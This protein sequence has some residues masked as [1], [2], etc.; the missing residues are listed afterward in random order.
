MEEQIEE[1]WMYEELVWCYTL[2]Y[3]KELTVA[4]L[5][6]LQEIVEEEFEYE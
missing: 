2:Q 6:R 5:N 3:K 4:V 1:L